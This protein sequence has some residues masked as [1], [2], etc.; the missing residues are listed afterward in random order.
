MAPVAVAFAV[1]AHGSV[2]DVG[3]VLAAGTV[4]VV[5][6]L[7]A[8]GVVGDRTSRRRLLLE[9]DSLRTLAEVALGLWVLV[10]H[11]PLWGFITLAALMGIGQ[12]FFTPAMTGIVP[13]LLSAD[14]LQQ[15]N[16]LNGISTSAGGIVG[17]ALAG[18][19]VSVSSPGWAILADAATYFVSVVSL[20]L[21]RVDWSATEHPEAFMALLREGWREFWA[22]SWLWA[23]V[24]QWSFVNAFFAAFFVLGPLVAK[25]SLGGASSWGA[26]LA[27]EGIGAVIGGVVML[28]VHPRRP[29]LVATLSTLVYPLPLFFLAARSA[30]AAVSAAAFVG[31]LFAAVFLVQWTTTMQREIP[32]HVLS[33]VSAYD[34]FGSLVFTPVGMALAGPVASKI[35]IRTTL[36]GCGALIILFVVATLFVPS[37]VRLTAPKSGGD[38]HTVST[39]S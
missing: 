1:L 36:V 22:R 38:A 13:Q 23:I 2:S 37:V 20:V 3:Y 19:I 18:V 29:L 8:G 26:I 7:L 6:L 15:G 4:P 32:D 34:W 17:P 30:T 35:G 16:A 10:G 12:A 28:R 14:L 31:G 25:E 33:R 9:A 24:I 5:V 11:P 21:I 39:P 27:A